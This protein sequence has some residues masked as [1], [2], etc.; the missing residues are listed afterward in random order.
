MGYG[1]Q[2]C[3]GG[4]FQHPHAV[5]AYPVV[6]LSLLVCCAAEY[7]NGSQ[8]FLDKI[9]SLQGTYSSMRRTR[10]D[11]NCFFRS[12]I[13]RYLEWLLLQQQEEECQR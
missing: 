4:L 11:G 5:E 2:G 9:S 13:Y 8:V 1:L 6:I 3:W 7:A 10:G 12:F